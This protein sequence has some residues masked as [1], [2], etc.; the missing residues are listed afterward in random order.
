MSLNMRPAGF[1][2]ARSVNK[3]DSGR[4]HLQFVFVAE[5]ST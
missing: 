1:S 5:V 3:E 4:V 2:N